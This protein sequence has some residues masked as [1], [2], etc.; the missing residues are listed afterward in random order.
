MIT[1]IIGLTGGLTVALRLLA[2]LI[3]KLA[4]K[5]WNYVTRQRR[6][7]VVL[8]VESSSIRLGKKIKK[9]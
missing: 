2:P 8:T 9:N 1:T 5:V 6:D 3:V 4:L 7:N